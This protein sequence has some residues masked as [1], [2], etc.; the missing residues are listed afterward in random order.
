M[1]IYCI[2]VKII[3]SIVLRISPAMIRNTLAGIVGVT[4]GVG[5]IVG[6]TVGVGVL[7]GVTEGVGVGE[8]PA[9]GTT[10]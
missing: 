1:N 5:V 4:V 10:L 8:G 2:V 9:G 3:S 6:V 7:V